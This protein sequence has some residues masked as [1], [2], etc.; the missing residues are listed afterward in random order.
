MRLRH[1]PEDRLHLQLERPQLLPEEAIGVEAR[2]EGEVGAL[3]R[4]LVDRPLEVEDR[5][6]I[7]RLETA[8]ERVDLALV[9]ELELDRLRPRR[10]GERWRGGRDLSWRG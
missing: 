8:E 2:R 9:V 6:V 10:R 4:L 1:P 7:D 3:D 5:V